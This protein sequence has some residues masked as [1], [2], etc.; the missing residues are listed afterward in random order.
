MTDL[1]APST[2]TLPATPVRVF[3]GQGTGLGAASQPRVG[4]GEQPASL[5]F[6]GDRRTQAETYFRGQGL[7]PAADASRTAAENDEQFNRAFEAYSRANGLGSGQAGNFLMALLSML[8]G[9][10]NEQGYGD[11]S[12]LGLPSSYGSFGNLRDRRQAMGAAAISGRVAPVEVEAGT[13]SAASMVV[14]LAQR[15]LGVREN[16]GGNRGADIARFGQAAGVGEGLPWCASFISYVYAR[17]GVEGIGGT[18]SALAF[19][20]QF[21]RA[22]AYH[23]F[24]DS[25]REPQ[26]GDVV[27]FSRGGPGSGQGHVGIVERVENGRVTLIEGNSG[28][29]VR[30]NT[31]SID[32]LRRGAHGARGFGSLDEATRNSTRFASRERDPVAPT[33]DI[34]PPAA[35][36]G[37]GRRGS[38]G[39]LSRD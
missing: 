38:D 28:D 9:V 1:P 35:T 24:R 2:P 13:R 39:Q 30:R 6:T 16:G 23:S 7:M 14:E 8:F 31:Y 37:A 5:L 4:A 29:A 10:G 15:E 17:A 12:S 20:S 25:R 26:P 33:T 19:E 36:P 3:A 27:V 21:Q 34:L 22:G 18:A 11:A 32:A